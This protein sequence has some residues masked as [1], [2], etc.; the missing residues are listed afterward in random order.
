VVETTVGEVPLF[1]S[2]AKAADKKISRDELLAFVDASMSNRTAPYRRVILG[3][4]S[5]DA[6]AR[7]EQKCH[8]RVEKST[9]II[10]T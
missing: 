6:R 9:L 7:L 3:D 10:K 2:K 8:V 1:V 5:N 4:I